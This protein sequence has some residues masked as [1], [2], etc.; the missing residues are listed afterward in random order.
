MDKRLNTR[1]TDCAFRLQWISQ[2]AY[3]KAES[4]NFKPRMELD[5][6]LFAENEFVKMLIMRYQ[7][8]SYEDGGMTTKGLQRLAKSLGVKHSEVIT[9]V[10]EL[11]HAIQK[12]TNNTPCFN[13]EL[14]TQCSVAEH[15]LWKEECKTNKIIARWK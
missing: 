2:A 5:D 6:W 14:E 11:I 1:P 15:C 7:V 12:I 10:D 13:V 9:Q 4:R 8:I 3:Y